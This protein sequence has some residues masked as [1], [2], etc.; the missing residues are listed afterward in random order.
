M[1]VDPDDGV[2][3]AAGRPVRVAAGR[4]D[5]VVEVFLE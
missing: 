2:G 1:R 4:V 5:V 3:V